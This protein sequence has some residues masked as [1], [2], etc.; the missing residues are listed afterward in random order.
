[1]R[2]AWATTCLGT[3]PNGRT[4]DADGVGIDTFWV[5]DC[6]AAIRFY[7]IF[8]FKG[9]E[10]D[11]RSG[12]S[13]SVDVCL[14]GARDGVIRDLSFDWEPS[15]LPSNHEPGWDASELVDVGVKFTAK[16]FGGY[17]V[18]TWFG[19]ERHV[20]SLHFTVRQGLPTP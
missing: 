7:L 8:C 6:P 16:H 9:S 20:Q 13:Y 15:P 18:D 19:G 3:N 1:M 10:A 14:S 5:I 11:F 17:C 2:L 12:N 4:V